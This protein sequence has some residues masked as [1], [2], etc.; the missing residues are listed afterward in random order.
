[1][2]SM[3]VTVTMNP[4]LDK[5]VTVDGFQPGGLNRIKTIR[6][7]AGGKGINVS[8][9]LSTYGVGQVATGILAGWN[10]NNISSMLGRY[11]VNQDFLHISGETRVN[12]KILDE[13]M[14]MI[15][16]LNEP[17]QSVGSVN[18]KS[19]FQQLENILKKADIL[20]LSGSLPPFTPN[21]F[22]ADCIQMANQMNVRTI[23]DSDGE[24]LKLG[25]RVKPYAI[26][27]NQKELEHLVGK[28]LNGK[29]EIIHEMKLLARSGIGVILVSM[30]DKGSILYHDHQIYLAK[31]YPVSVQSTVACGDAM[32]AALA[33]CIQ[34][35]LPIEEMARI[36]AA[37]GSL[38]AGKK[39]SETAGW[40]EIQKM[41]RNIDTIAF[42]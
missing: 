12:L 36:T 34:R 11:G 10:G 9:A 17:G 13:K 14:N 15:T 23:L 3:I 32:V 31:T 38:T 21:D 19:F 39:G 1:M 16:E 30:G 27:P 4:A 18:L 20:V 2:K 6:M 41:Y 24:A 37:A 5:M 40:A 8:K 26:K 42:L 25:I 7:D 28:S 22:Y 35:D 29:E 33:Y